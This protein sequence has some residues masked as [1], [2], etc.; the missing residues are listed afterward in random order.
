MRARLALMFLMAGMALP[1]LPAAAHEYV[2]GALEIVHPWARASSGSAK[3]G[4]AYLDIVSH[5]ETADRLIAASSPMAASAELHMHASENG[6]MKMRPIEAV[7]IAPGQHI[8][9]RPGSFHIMLSGLTGPLVEGESFPLVLT[10]EQAGQIEVSVTI[11]SVATMHSM[12]GASPPK[13]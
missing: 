2:L 4:A 13:P 1:P 12:H 7:E 11:A 3:N 9:L 5:A 6:I 8:V 10:F